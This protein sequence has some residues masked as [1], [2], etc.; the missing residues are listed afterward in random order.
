MSYW[1]KNI[2]KSRTVPGQSSFQ[3]PLRGRDFS[4]LIDSFMCSMQLSNHA[5]QFPG[6]IDTHKV[7][8]LLTCIEDPVEGGVREMTLELCEGTLVK[9]CEWWS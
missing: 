5:V 7:S 9:T 8:V 2:W 4:S 6:F 3:Q 1:W